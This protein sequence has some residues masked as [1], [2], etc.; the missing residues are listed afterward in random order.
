M[1]EMNAD[2]SEVI[3]SL[4]KKRKDLMDLLS[5]TSDRSKKTINA[6]KPSSSLKFIT[7][8]FKDLFAN[9]NNLSEPLRNLKSNIELVHFV[10]ISTGDSLKAVSTLLFRGKKKANLKPRP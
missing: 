4:F 8:V 6:N 1:N 2:T 5:S 9:E 3:L 7:K 10:V